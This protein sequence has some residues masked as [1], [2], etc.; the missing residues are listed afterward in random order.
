M[1]GTNGSAGRERSS[2]AIR[3][4]PYAALAVLFLSSL[5]LGCWLLEVIVVKGWEGLNWLRGFPLAAC[6]VCVCVSLSILI[7]VLREAR[8][9]ARRAAA[10]IILATALSLTSFVITMNWF[11]TMRW[12]GVHTSLAGIIISPILSVFLSAVGLHLLTRALLFKISHLNIALIAVA[13]LLVNALSFVTIQVIPSMH[14]HKDF[15]HAIKMGYPTFWVN[16]LLAASTE[17]ALRLT[18]RGRRE[19]VHDTTPR[20]R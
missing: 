1:I 19:D 7:P 12:P 11:L 13:L 10:F 15:I 16:I 9:S 4:P 5:S 2:P 20:P 17:L 6:P 8:P 14:G 3:H 18:A